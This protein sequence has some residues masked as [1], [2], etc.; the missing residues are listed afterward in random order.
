[1][2]SHNTAMVDDAEWLSAIEAVHLISPSI[3]GDKK[4]KE[5]IAARLH[6]GVI[7]PRALWTAEGANLGE[8]FVTRSLEFEDEREMG[9][10]NNP[11]ALTI[12]MT[13]PQE[14]LNKAGS[15]Y[16]YRVNLSEKRAIRLGPAFWARSVNWKRDQKRWEWGKG[17]LMVTT[18][19]LGDLHPNPR[20]MEAQW[21]LRN[22]AYGVQFK[23]SDIIAIVNPASIA[24]AKI[25]KREPLRRRASKHDWDPV[26]IDLIA[27]GFLGNSNQF[28]GPHGLRGWQGSVE[29]WILD[30]FSHDGLEASETTVKNKVA[31]IRDAINKLNQ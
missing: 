10:V 29:K 28:F 2:T 8:P 19:P 21:G 20:I 24:E 23:R 22:V 16:A 1:M 31:A 14:T 5:A 13:A 30:R 9:A 7:I 27:I 11:D 6:D 15:G 17:L 18:E 12:R 3:G 25:E 4:A 26:L